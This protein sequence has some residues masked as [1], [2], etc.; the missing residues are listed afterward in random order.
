MKQTDVTTIP[1]ADVKKRLKQIGKTKGRA[2]EPAAQQEIRQL[3]GSTPRRR[4]LLI[5]HLHVIQDKYQH[6][7]ARHLAALAA[8]MKLSMAEVYEVA[9]FYHHFDV[10][11][12][13]ETAPPML[14]VRVCD[15]VS[16]HMAG[17]DKLV[18]ELTVSL[19]SDIRVQRVPCV[20]RCDTAPVAVVGQNPVDQATAA[21][22]QKI[23]QQN[24]IKSALPDYIRY[25]AYKKTDGYQLLRD[26]VAGKR[27]AEAVITKWNTP[28]CAASAARVSRRVENGASCAPK[29]RR[30]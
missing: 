16:C 20:G 25:D 30:N 26:C 29:L 10:V 13:S 2:L 14:T 5:E 17:A 3:L 27:E 15:S 18:N 28:V 9:T 19:G 21:N 1:L 7:S 11:K 12:E 8:E 22:V 23:V 24:Q 4:D 6:I